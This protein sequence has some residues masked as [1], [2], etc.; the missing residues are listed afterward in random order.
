MLVAQARRSRA[1]ALVRCA[2][3]AQSEEAA[4]EPLRRGHLARIGSVRQAAEAVAGI[5]R[6]G[7]ADPL[8]TA[9]LLIS[10][11][12]AYAWVPDAPKPPAPVAQEDQ[13]LKNEDFRM[14]LAMV[15]AREAVAERLAYH[16]INEA[17]PDEPEM[18]EEFDCPED[19][20]GRHDTSHI[21]CGPDAVFEDLAGHGVE[22]E[23]PEPEPLSP[24]PRA[25][26]SNPNAKSED[27]RFPD[28][29]ENAENVLVHLGIDTN[30]VDTIL[31]A[32]AVGL[33]VDAWRNGPLDAI[34]ASSG[35]PSDGEIFAQSVDLYRRAR[36][37]LLAARDD[38]P[39]MLSLFAAIASDVRLSWAGGS[40]FRLCGVPAANAE[41]VAQFVEQVDNQVWFTGEVM[42]A[43]GWRAALMHRAVSAALYGHHHF[44]M[45]SWPSI[46]A[47]AMPQLA[48]LD[49]TDAPQILGDLVS[50][51]KALL[52][53]PDQLGAE[54]LEWL[55][56]R[57]LLVSVPST[58]PTGSEAAS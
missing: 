22:I 4:W 6:E 42:R 21:D 13:E 51:E 40:P 48:L 29:E 46:V 38:G 39:R 5:A 56:H 57:M 7:K 44:G 15:S 11:E 47:A 34:H 16:L 45:P 58:R 36:E 17:Q 28:I 43:R 1:D 14:N 27:A 24:I 26:L 9:W 55:S 3:Q 32:A 49:R 23:P 33:V 19:C 53:A 50:V 2:E 12:S 8:R 35:G 41:D 18:C 31:N 52:E 20:S 25:R 30:D 37:A 54:A 10:L